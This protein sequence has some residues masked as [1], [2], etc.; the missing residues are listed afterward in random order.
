MTRTE[1]MMVR[2]HELRDGINLRLI[3]GSLILKEAGKKERREV[4]VQP[5]GL[6]CFDFY[7]NSGGQRAPAY[8]HQ[9][10]FKN[11]FLGS[12]S[13]H[14]LQPME[15]RLLWSRQTKGLGRE[16]QLSLEHLDVPITCNRLINREWG[17]VPCSWVKEKENGQRRERQ[18]KEQLVLLF[19]FG[20]KGEGSL[21][22]GTRKWY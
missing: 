18:E 15:P 13:S 22:A 7:K 6:C 1:Q 12:K 16:R 5:S 17:R 8:Q 4:E 20:S 2:D 19:T 11:K 10:L 9:M 3:S 21:W 14:S